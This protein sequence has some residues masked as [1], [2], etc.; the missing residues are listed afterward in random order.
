MNKK[1]LS[2]LTAFVIIVLPLFSV[3]AEAIKT[4]IRLSCSVDGSMPSD[5][6]FEI[7][8]KKYAIDEADDDAEPVSTDKLTID[9]ASSPPYKDYEF[10]AGDIGLYRFD[11]YISG[12]SDSSIASDGSIVTVYPGQDEIRV[13]YPDGEKTYDLAG[14]KEPPKVT[15]KG[16]KVQQVKIE[17]ADNKTVSKVYDG[18]T[19]VSIPADCY[20]LIGV[21][22]GDDVKL[23]Y[24]S[25]V[26]NSPDVKSAK[27]V[28]VTGLSLTGNDAAKYKLATESFEIT[29]KITARPIT[30]TAND[31][32]IT[33]GANEPELTYTLSEQLIEGNSAVGTLARTAG[34]EA[35]SYI[36]TRGTLTFGD[37]YEV[38]FVEGHLTVSSYTLVEIIDQVLG[39]KISGYIDKSSSVSA[40]KLAQSDGS[41][42]ALADAAG[43][44][45]HVIAAYNIM[46]DTPK[47]DGDLTV[48]FPVD[49]KYE[50]K[51]I[52]IYQLMSSGAVSS[53]KTAAVDGTVS[54]KTSECTQFAIV[55]EGQVE[56]KPIPKTSV[57]KTILKVILILL[58]VVLGLA[59]LIALFF[60]GMVFFNKT[61]ELK[62]IIKKFRRLFKKNKR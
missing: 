12:C 46:L 57:G 15:V 44:V 2:L 45:G 43:S 5:K 52:Y 14:I 10:A 31:I 11:F 9:T 33:E 36:I 60:F 55:A 7:T 8:V 48:T 22:S 59:L 28:K 19:S 38:T 20:K 41:Y 32:V 35:G 21:V 62:R 34:S 61:D 16:T 3:S 49:A 1:I 29:G 23:A 6:K 53:Y 25:A 30:V 24:K 58:A 4:A 18:K 37:N 51:Q 17:L 40:V 47:H 50:G 42:K 56:A 26:F 39:I 54:L 27:R 13:S